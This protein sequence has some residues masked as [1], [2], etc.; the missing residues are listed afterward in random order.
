MS[1]RQLDLFVGGSSNG[2]GGGFRDPAFTENKTVPIHRW[3]PW[4]AGYSAQFIDD[5]LTAYGPLVKRPAKPLRVLDPFAGVGTTLVQSMVRGC[6]TRGFEINPFA[7]LA[8]QMKV[9]SPWFEIAKLDSAVRT[10]QEAARTFSADRLHPTTPPPSGFRSR[11]PFFSPKIESKVL[12]TLGFINRIGD[13]D[14]RNVFRIAFGSVM[15]SFSNYSFEPS[16]GTRAAAGK[17]LIDDADVPAIL[18][19][20]L[21]HMRADILWLQNEFDGSSPARD[22]VIYNEDFLANAEGRLGENAVDLMITSPPYMNNYHYVRNSRPHMYWLSMVTSRSDTRH[23]EEVNFG[24]FWQTVRCA[25]KVDLDFRTD[26]L[27]RKLEE[28]R[29]IR[30]EKGPYGGPGWANYVATYVNDSQRFLRVLHR[31]LRPE[32]IGVI[33]IGNSI[34]QGVEFGVDGIL[35]EIA[36]AN[37]YRVEKIFRLRDKRVGAS[38]T[39]SAVRRGKQNGAALYESAVVIQKRLSS[40]PKARRRPK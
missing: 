35:A 10:Y 12:L 26:A 2:N 15:V 20:K 36:S 21:R 16:L 34:I 30:S 1:A 27:V 40:K 17:Q 28:L 31:V 33:V 18:L 6:V 5:V 9:N 32:G 14:I 37:G 24:K 23:L 3:V 11:I 39:Q 7:A 25:P 8:A 29:G 4:I 38:I 19:E 13:A 22:H